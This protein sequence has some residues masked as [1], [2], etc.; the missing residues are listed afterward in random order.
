MLRAERIPESELN[1]ERTP[2][3]AIGSN[4][5]PEQLGRKFQPSRFPTGVVIPVLKAV[6]WDFDVV[7]A[8]V[9]AAY[10][11]CAGLLFFSCLLLLLS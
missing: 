8:P 11:S 1:L 7:Y 10:G 5:A 6:L 2:V 4:G 3:L 9:I